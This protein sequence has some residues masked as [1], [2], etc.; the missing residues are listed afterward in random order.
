[1]PL[2]L[3]LSEGLGRTM[4]LLRL[5]PP[6]TKCSGR[7]GFGSVAVGT[8]RRHRALQQQRVVD[9]QCAGDLPA[10]AGNLHRHRA[11]GAGLEGEL[12]FVQLAAAW[13]ATRRCCLQLQLHRLARPQRPSG[14]YFQRV[15]AGA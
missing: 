15:A 11:S 9:L 8:L 12:Q 10:V 2:A 4:L 5:M 13:C 1:M 7:S 3:R 6:L 14:C